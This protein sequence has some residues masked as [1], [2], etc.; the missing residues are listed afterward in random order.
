MSVF[1][2]LMLVC[3]GASWPFS[4]EKTLRTKKVDGKSPLFLAIVCIGYLC[5]IVHKL[6]YSLDWVLALYVVNLALV[7]ADFLLYYRYKTPQMS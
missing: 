4:I 5:G 2:I 7:F 6:V 3:F 1:E